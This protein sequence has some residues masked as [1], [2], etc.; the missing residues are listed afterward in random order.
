MINV[1]LT[2]QRYGRLTIIKY[3]YSKNDRKYWHCKCD[4]GNEKVIS[5]HDIRLG[6][7]KSCGCL[8]KENSANMLRT[9]GA[10]DTRLYHIWCSMKQ[11]CLKPTS[12]KHKKNYFDRGICICDEW[13]VFENFQKWA[14]E[15]GYQDNL[16]IDRIDNNGNYC[17]ENCRWVDY[18]T[19]ANN[20][21]SNR[22]ITYNGETKTVAQ[23]ADKI[24]MKYNCLIMRLCNGWTVE[25]AITIPL[26]GRRKICRA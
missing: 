10:T 17:P 16:T 22:L 11:R 7:T 5:S 4:C 3:A 1:D 6:R 18:K 26:K 2:N 13:T 20:K 24:G 19:Q 12:N 25:E 21:S 14:L 8:K 9:H 23:W 15:N